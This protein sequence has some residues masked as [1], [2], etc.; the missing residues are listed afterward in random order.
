A[1]LIQAPVMTTLPGK[2]A[3]PEDHPLSVGTG[4]YSG[5]GA[6]GHF[7]QR[8]DVLFGIS[9]SFTSTIFGAPI[10][11]GKTVIHLTNNE[12]D[13]NKDVPADVAILGDARLAL[14]QL[15]EE[16]ERQGGRWADSPADEIASV[17]QA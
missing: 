17:K 2:S 6:A 11:P 8:A 13:V 7:L 16:V 10:P 5:T 9:C 15:I 1:E 4:G 14:R 3:F 12:A